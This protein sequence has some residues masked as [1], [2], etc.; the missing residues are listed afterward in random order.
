M[1]ERNLFLANTPLIVLEAAAAARAQG[2]RAQLV[3]LEDF[4]LA[5]RLAALLRR[6]RDNPFEDIVRLPGRHEEHRRGP[7]AQRGPGALLRRIAVKR[8]IRHDT[9]AVLREL[10][11]HFQPDAVWVGNDKKVETQYALHLASRRT[12]ARA[13]RYLDDGLH[14]YLGRY[15]ERPLV[16]RVDELVKRIGYGRWFRWVPQIGTSPWI[17]EAWLAFPDE[18]VDQD[19]ARLRRELPRAWFAGRDFRRLAVLAA[20]EFGVDRE[21]L[22][23]CSAI[24]LLPHSKLLRGNEALLLTL[25]RMMA[26]AEACGRC[27]AL[28]YHPREREDDP[29]GLLEDGDALVLPKLL[30][31]ELMVPLLPPG[32]LLAGEGT[33]AILAAHWLR[34]DLAVRDLGS[35]RG[36]YA[37]RARAL[38]QRHGI[39]LLDETALAAGAAALA[40]PFPA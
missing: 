30:P 14:T 6:W 28:K 22:R 23:G 39:Q 10:D 9:F 4:D 38:F 27:V 12:G 8:D 7:G 21:A 20:R 17:D 11:A 16:R 15:R 36:D 31:M 29:F 33:T 40:P 25:R 24:V 35:A 2:R 3:L 18:A 26:S 19:P 34:P 37:Q 13:G 1:G 5:G 32:A